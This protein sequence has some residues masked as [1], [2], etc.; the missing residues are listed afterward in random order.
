MVR[1]PTERYP[2]FRFF[3]ENLDF[4]IIDHGYGKVGQ[5]WT[6]SADHKAAC[7]RLTLVFDG[8]AFLV[9]NNRRI[10]FQKNGLY[11][12][13]VNSV[14]R[15]VCEDYFVC[16][17]I[18]FHLEIYPLQDI[19]DGVDHCLCRQ[20]D[21]PALFNEILRKARGKKAADVIEAKTLLLNTIAGFIDMHAP[22]VKRKILLG[23]KYKLVFREIENN[24]PAAIS[25]AKLAALLH[26]APITFARMFRRDMGK[27]LKAY[28]DDKTLEKGKR[29][30]LFTSLKI[31][32]IAHELGFEDEFYFSRFFKKHVRLAP[33]EYRV[34]NKD[35]A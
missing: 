17:Y 4:K 30:L 2:F 28:I 29:Q 8:R 9:E 23:E 21:N 5:W 10:V 18:H 11:L 15:Q 13:P 22:S 6:Q 7:N 25:P 32:E 33:S 19:F 20:I 16:F 1:R 3:S 34:K 35:W 31:K 12:N 26:L 14:Y 27:T 24:P